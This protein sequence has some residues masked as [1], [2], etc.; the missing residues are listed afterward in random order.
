MGVSNAGQLAGTTALCSEFRAY[1]AGSPEDETLNAK[2]CRRPDRDSAI[3]LQ[4]SRS[5]M[6]L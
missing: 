5:T 3:A 4:M 6:L 2:R 1:A